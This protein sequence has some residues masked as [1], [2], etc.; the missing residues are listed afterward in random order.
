MVMPGSAN[1][2]PAP[3]VMSAPTVMVAGIPAA[4]ET[5]VL[6]VP[7]VSISTAPIITVVISVVVST[8][9]GFNYDTGRL[10]QRARCGE[11]AD[12]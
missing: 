2:Y 9:A 3:F 12:S 1:F 5:I 6:V 4:M 7:I 8:I 11:T 10:S